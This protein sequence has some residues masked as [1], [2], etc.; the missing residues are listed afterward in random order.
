MIVL[1]RIPNRLR[2]DG[3]DDRR[4]LIGLGTL[5]RGARFRVLPFILRKDCRAILGADIIALAIELG[6]IVRC[7]ENR[8]QVAVADDLRI[9][10]DPDRLGMA[11]APATHLAI[12]RIGGRAASVAALDPA[13]A[14]D[15]EEHRLGAPETSARQDGHL[16]GHDLLLVEAREMA[17]R[18]P[19]RKG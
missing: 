9:E 3:G 18:L 19:G 13:H 2:L 10:T 17:T 15:I 14:R 5:D 8:E 4:R 6:W 7:K 1:G 16:L 11:G 12:G